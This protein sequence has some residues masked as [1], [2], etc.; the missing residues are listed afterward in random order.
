MEPS[1]ARATVLSVRVDHAT[2]A[3]IDL[4]VQAGLAQSRSEGAAQLIAI[5]V[6]AATEMLDR[7]RAVATQVQQLREQ[8][9]RAV[10]AQDV[11]AVRTMLEQDPALLQRWNEGGDT[12]L[13]LSVYYGA[14][15]VTQTLLVHGAQLT[16]FEAAAAGQIERVTQLATDTPALIQTLSHDGWTALHLAAYFGYPDIVEWVLAHGTDINAR[17]A[18]ALGNTA[19]HAALA[20]RRFDC[21]ELLI[22]HGADVNA[23]DA[24]GW[25]I[26]HHIAANGTLELLDLALAHGAVAPARNTD[27]DTPAQ[28]AHKAGHTAIGDRLNE[29]ET[30]Q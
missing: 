30:K 2:I 24:A 11:A 9:M 23:T 27:G 26:L 29:M 8:M 5:G 14:R 12:P 16:I 4:L 3:A 19:L 25:S 28:I 1:H 20:G 21:A 18:N 6:S 7:A 13:L 10:K 15:D 22:Q 17:S